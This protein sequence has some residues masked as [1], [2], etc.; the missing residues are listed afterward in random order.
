MNLRFP[1]CY[2][3][4]LRAFPQTYRECGVVIYCVWSICRQPMVVG[5]CS[6]KSD[7]TVGDGYGI[8]EHLH[9]F[10]VVNYLQSYSKT[11]WMGM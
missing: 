5:F 4:V 11:L 7:A 6:I 9:S 2:S 8:C 3:W 1:L 10:R